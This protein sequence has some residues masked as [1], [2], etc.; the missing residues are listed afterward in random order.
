MLPKPYLNIILPGPEVPM[1]SQEEPQQIVA[2]EDELQQ[3]EPNQEEDKE[4][5]LQQKEP[6]QEEDKENG[7]KPQQIVALEDEQQQK[8]PHQEED[9]EN[10]DKP[11]STKG[12]LTWT[13]VYLTLHINSKIILLTL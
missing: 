7:D 3:K 8:E 1:K 13:A 4:N 2:M 10:G 9:K 11:W 6:N 5:E 12:A